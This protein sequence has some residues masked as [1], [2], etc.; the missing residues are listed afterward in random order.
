MLLPLALLAGV[1]PAGTGC[2]TAGRVIR[3][4][5][6]VLESQ[7]TADGVRIDVMDPE[8]LFLEGAKAF[9]E[10]RHEEAARNFGLIVERF[11]D[12][13]LLKPA[14]YNRALALLAWPRPEEAARDFEAY[15]ERFPG[16]ADATDAWMKLGQAWSESGEW[17]KADGALASRLKMEPLTLL[18]EVEI[19]A[20]LARG[21]RM[22]GRYE[23]TH[24][25][26][27]AVKSLHDRYRTLPEMDGNFFV[28]MA[29]FEGAEAYRDLFTRI[30]FV[31]PVDRMEKDL[32]DKATL[33]LKAQSEYLATIRLRNTYWGVKAG[34]RVGRMYEE[35]FDDIMNAEIPPELAPDEVEIYMNEL[36]KKT[37][38]LV[39]KAVDSYERNMV[40]ARMYGAKD[41]WFDDTQER[42]S[43]L[44]KVLE[45]LPK[46]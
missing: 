38:P 27:K 25:Q 16:D 34:V 7:Q 33:F 10:K 26:I 24:G 6:L 15:L 1:V 14:L 13:R 37:R 46:E 35:F 32:I 17:E 43:R 42:L 11:S 30:K 31:L 22:L 45:E 8:V 44:R 40:L 18:Q 39:R 3:M 28:S 36:K 4:D 20:R 5:P 12:S 19:R 21:A 23:E 29:S 2:G 9:E 41:Q